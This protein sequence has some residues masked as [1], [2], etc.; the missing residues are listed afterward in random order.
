MA[1][2]TSDECER[3]AVEAGASMMALTARTAPKTRGLDSVKTVVL[4]GQE[5]ESLATA[6][7]NKLTEKSTRLLIFKRDADNV[8]NSA[9]LCS[10]GS[11]EILKGSNCLL[12]AGPAGTRTAR[13]SPV[14]MG[15]EGRIS[16]A[17]P[18]CFKPSTWVSPLVRPS[19]WLRSWVS[20][21]ASCIRSALLLRP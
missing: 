12:T 21:I 4:T 1:I 5:L 3:E 13:I 2:K 8:R 17:L 19:S 14:R 11:R 20:I 10:S 6:M 9:A 18:A 16:Q 15:E 7:E